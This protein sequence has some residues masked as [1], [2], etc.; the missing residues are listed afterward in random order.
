MLVSG[1]NTWPPTG[2]GRPP[3]TDSVA[4][5]VVMAIHNSG[6]RKV[7]AFIVYPIGL[8]LLNT[9]CIRVMYWNCLLTHDRYVAASIY[10]DCVESKLNQSK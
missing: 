3:A 10:H 4:P 9:R 5:A 8:R 1:I 6:E 2:S 7:R